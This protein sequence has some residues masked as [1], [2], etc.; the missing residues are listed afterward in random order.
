MKN[1]IGQRYGKLTAIEKL[2]QDSNRHTKYRFR[3]NCGGETIRTLQSL[4]VAMPNCGCLKKEFGRLS[5]DDLKSDEYCRGTRE[6]MSRVTVASS[7][8]RYPW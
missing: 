8:V 7:S 6:I 3:C 5:A 1:I 2:N 4:N